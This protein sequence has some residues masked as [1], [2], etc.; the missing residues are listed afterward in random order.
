MKKNI[1]LKMIVASLLLV[2]LC[3]VSVLAQNTEKQLNNQVKARKKELKKQKMEF[4]SSGLGIDADL[5]NYFEKVSTKNYKPIEGNSKGRNLNILKQTA[6]NNAQNLYAQ[7]INGNIKGA[8]AN[9]TKNDANNSGE[10][11]DKT[12]AAFTKE[13]E[14]NVGGIIEVYYCAYK[15]ADNGIKDFYAYCLIDKKA[16]AKFMKSALE[17]SIQETKLTIEQAQ[18]IT[19][20]VSDELLKAEPK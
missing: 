11:M 14:A 15:E 1:T 6:L 20:F 10:E 2:F 16:E 13:V 4:V 12:V 9:I 3:P 8:V 17:S 18:S 7:Q 5:Y 19:K